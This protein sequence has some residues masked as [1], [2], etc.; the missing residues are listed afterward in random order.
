MPFATISIRA[1]SQSEERYIV[2]PPSDTRPPL[3]VSLPLTVPDRLRVSL[4]VLP[5][6]YRSTVVPVANGRPLP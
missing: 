6:P 1:K 5:L 3:I 4:L 2:A